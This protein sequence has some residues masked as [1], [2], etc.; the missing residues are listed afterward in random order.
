MSVRAKFRVTSITETEAN[1]TNEA[2]EKVFQKTV[3]LSPVYGNN[4]ENK[5]FFE[6]TPT[7]FMELGI[8]NANA[9]NQFTPGKEFY[10]DFTAA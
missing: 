2:G 10:V 5:R 1:R 8:L 4:E 6:S 3:K 7:G 9:S